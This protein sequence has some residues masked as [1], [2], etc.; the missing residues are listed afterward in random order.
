MPRVTGFSPARAVCTELPAGSSTRVAWREYRIDALAAGAAICAVPLS[1][2]VTESFLVIALVARLIYLVR[3]HVGIRPPRVFWWWTVWAALEI[4]SWLQSPQIRA[5]WGEIRHLLLLG[6]V[7]LI[8]PP[9]YRA[10]TR[11]AVWRGIFLMASVGS[12]ALV[13]AFV[14]R[15]IRYR[16]QIAAGGDPAFYLRTGGLL[17]HWMIYSVVEVLVFGALLEFRRSYPEQRSWVMPMLAINGLAIC[18]SLTRGLWLACFILLGV[19][20]ISRWSK[21]TWALPLIP[22]IAFF[23]APGPLKARISQ[24]LQWDYY[25]NAERVQM[26]TVGLRMIR[27]RPLTGVGAGR[28]EELYTRYLPPGAPVP[29]YHGHL[30]NNALQLGAQFGLPVLLAALCCVGALLWDLAQKY[31]QAYRRDDRFLCRAALIGTAGF[32]ITGMT[33]YTYGHS[34]GLILFSFVALSP[35]VGKSGRSEKAGNGDREFGQ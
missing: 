35:L 1:I 6:S 19:H 2:A 15:A 29:A 25:A 30:H 14:E 33:D 5:G 16:H 31:R 27:E 22:A 17:H 13:C 28:V 8:L 23:A 3:Y 18:L 4:V 32:L 11:L 26:W 12:A 20:L 34:L 10:K 21:W 9:L 24:S 7:F